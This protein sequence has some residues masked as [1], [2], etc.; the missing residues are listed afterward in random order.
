MSEIVDVEYSKLDET[1]PTV[2]NVDKNKLKMTTVS[3]YSVSKISGSNKLVYLIKKY[4]KTDNL[5]ITDGTTTIICDVTNLKGKVD[6][7]L[8]TSL[9]EIADELEENNNLLNG[10]TN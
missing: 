9:R 1:F 4:F 5:T 7:E 3:L 8:I 6:T 10:K 2:K